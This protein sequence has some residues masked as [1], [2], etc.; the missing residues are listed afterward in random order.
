VFHAWSDDDHATL[1]KHHNS[2]SARSKL[3]RSN[4]VQHS[5]DMVAKGTRVPS[6]GYAGDGYVLYKDMSASTEEDI[7]AMFH[8]AWVS[9]SC[10]R[11]LNTEMAFRTQKA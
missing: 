11:C 1:V 3:R 6:G 4:N 5:G 7:E 2:V 8:H 9:M 10:S